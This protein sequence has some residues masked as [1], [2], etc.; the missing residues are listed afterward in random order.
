VWFRNTNLKTYYNK[1][2]NG[3]FFLRFNTIL[4]TNCLNT[5]SVF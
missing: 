1:F 5:S 2:L 3:V 4:V